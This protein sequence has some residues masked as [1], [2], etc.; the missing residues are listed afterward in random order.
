MIVDSADLK[1]RQK[2]T[3]EVRSVSISPKRH[4]ALMR[5]MPRPVPVD[6]G[7]RPRR[8]Y[9]FGMLVSMLAKG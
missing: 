8:L 1:S 6:A 2:E 7:P 4:T 9:L 3:I 5:V